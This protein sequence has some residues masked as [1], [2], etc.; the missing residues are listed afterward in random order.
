MKRY[1]RLNQ[2]VEYTSIS[3]A[4]IWRLAASD[5]F[6]K[7]IKTSMGTTVW[8]IRDIDKFMDGKREVAKP[9][10]GWESD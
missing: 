1:L 7:P 9:S 4:T 10:V 8:D 5:K 3:R 6:P 2:V